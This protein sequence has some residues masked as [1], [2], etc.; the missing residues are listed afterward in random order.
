MV[1]ALL[2]SLGACPCKPES[3]RS[4]SCHLAEPN[5]TLHSTT[6]AGFKRLAEASV[7]K[8]PGMEPQQVAD[9]VVGFRR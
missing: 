4:W 7:T 8:V 3:L 1:P 2:V 5:L 9:L 6:Q